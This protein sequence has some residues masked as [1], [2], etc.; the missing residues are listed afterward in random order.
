[1]C[2]SEILLSS[3][4][5]M[6]KRVS[7]AEAEEKLMVQCRHETDRL[8]SRKEIDLCAGISSTSTQPGPALVLMGRC[9]C[10]LKWCWVY[11]QLMKSDMIN[12]Q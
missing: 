12:T 3:N 1:M 11:I 4:S 7:I 10:L 2:P 5:T 6:D 9:R 8:M